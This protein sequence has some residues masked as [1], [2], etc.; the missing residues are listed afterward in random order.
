MAIGRDPDVRESRPWPDQ[1]SPHEKKELYIVS[2]TSN[3]SPGAAIVSNAE[4]EICPTDD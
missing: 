2:H 1:Y 4:A 3:S